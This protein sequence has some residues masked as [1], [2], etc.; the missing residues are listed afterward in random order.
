MK[1]EDVRN[2]RPPQEVAQWMFDV[3]MRRGFLD[4]ETAVHEIQRRFGRDH[5][6]ENENGN[7]AI[8]KD[9]LAAFQKLDRDD[10]I[11]WEEG[12]S[13]LWRKRQPYDKPG[14]R[15]D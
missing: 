5:I 11:V 7:P 15:Q 12:G 10:E 13:R 8:N 4:Q 14:R 3:V 9:V 6:Y 1:L 2:S